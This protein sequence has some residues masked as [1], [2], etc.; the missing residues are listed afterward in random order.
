MSIFIVRH[1]ETTFNAAKVFQHP[2]TPLSEKGEA[3]AKCVARR[4]AALGVA[5]I[6]SSDYQRALSTA[7][8]LSR[9]TGVAVEVEIGL[10]ERNFGDLRGVPHADIDFDAHAADY[11]PANG[12]S[13]LDFHD[14]VAI[15]WDFIRSQAAQTNGNLAVVTHGLVCLALAERHLGLVRGHDLPDH[16]P[17]TALTIVDSQPPYTV[18]LVG[19]GSH[20]DNPGVADGGRMYGL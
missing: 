8:E 19:D 4:L 10:R 5:A 18:Q 3:Q 2:D 11:H 13:W 7:N 15:A 14:R 12:E 6:V 1:G 20:L 16:W 17:N 9:Q